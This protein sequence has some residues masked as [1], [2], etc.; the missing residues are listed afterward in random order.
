MLVRNSDGTLFATGAMTYN[1]DPELVTSTQIVLQVYIGGLLTEAFVD[2]NSQYVICTP[3]TADAIG[4]DPDKAEFNGEIQEIR[5]GGE[6]VKGR[7]YKV[8]VRFEPDENKGRGVGVNAF[9][10]VVDEEED[11]SHFFVDE[12]PSSIGFT[13]CLESICFA[14]DGNRRLF[15]FG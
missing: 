13:G 4:F 8:E 2:T 1:A 9:A 15:Y 12:I 14:V 6:L 7:V 5:V 11:R 10:F 3:D